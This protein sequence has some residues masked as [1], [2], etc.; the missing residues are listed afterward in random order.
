MLAVIPAHVLTYEFA[1]VS[2]GCA[3]TGAGLNGN[4]TR[5]TDTHSGGTPAVVS[6]CYDKADRLTSTTATGAVSGA[7]P[8]TDGLAG[9]ELVYDAH[10]NTA[11]LADQTLGY[12]VADQ[13]VSMVVAGGPTIT[14]LRDVAGSVVQRTSSTDTDPSVR[15]T[16]GAVLSGTTGAILQRTLS[17]PGGVNV[18]IDG[19]AIQWSYPSLHGDS[20]ILADGAGLRQGARASYDP[21]GQPIDPVTGDIGT[22]VA[23]DAVA[24]TTPGSADHAWAGGAGKLYEHQGSVATIE[25]GARQYVAALGRFLEVDPVEG[26]VSNSYDYPADPVNG[27]DLSGLM[28]A[29][30]YVAMLERKQTPVWVPSGGKPQQ[31]G[32]GYSLSYP[33]QYPALGSGNLVSGTDVWSKVLSTLSGTFPISGMG[34]NPSRGQTF[35]LGGSNPVEVMNVGVRSITLKSLPGHAEGAGNYIVFE[36]SEDGTTFDVTAWGPKAVAFPVSLVPYAAWPLFASNVS[37]SINIGYNPWS[38]SWR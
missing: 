22:A 11:T 15:Y 28:T 32:Y 3:V 37:S 38:G 33:I 5:S 14:Y 27:S 9:A 18:T 10:G 16:A 12:D 19:S 6:S 25:M 30:S 26:G 35:I 13:H 31:H 36:V 1:T 23:D 4:R 24:D 29:D 21:F 8:V 17:L 7:S 2:S 34:N 20:I